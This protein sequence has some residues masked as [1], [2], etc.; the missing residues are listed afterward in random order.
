[1]VAPQRSHSR[2]S[3]PSHR[4]KRRRA[5]NE[6]KHGRNPENA[7]SDTNRLSAFVGNGEGKPHGIAVVREFP[8]EAGRDGGRELRAANCRTPSNVE[9]QVALPGVS[10]VE[11][12]PSRAAVPQE[13]IVPRRRQNPMRTAGRVATASGRPRISPPRTPCR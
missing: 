11:T 3:R 2:R 5:V 13:V 10:V 9:T 6:T 12:I 7:S 1:M 8:T 4:P